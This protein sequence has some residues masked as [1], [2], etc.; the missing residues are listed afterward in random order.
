MSAAFIAGVTG[1]TGERDRGSSFAAVNHLLHDDRESKMVNK[2]RHRI[3][4]KTQPVGG[5]NYG[6]VPVV[7][8]RP[9]KVNIEGELNAV[10]I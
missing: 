6:N 2:G 7:V 3:L 10:V 4:G 8:S 1:D 9:F 5:N